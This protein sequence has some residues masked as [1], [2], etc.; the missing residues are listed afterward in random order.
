MDM[1]KSHEKYFSIHFLHF[2]S[3]QVHPE[4]DVF[5]NFV[6]HRLHC[7][8]KFDDNEGTRSLTFYVEDPSQIR[9]YFDRMAYDKCKP[10][11]NDF[12]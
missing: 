9:R 11:S 3:L 4:W 2:L 7:M 8:L 10:I 6:K 5:Q 12:K 1:L